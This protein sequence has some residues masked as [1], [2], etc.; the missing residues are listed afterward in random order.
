MSSKQI[1]M[2]FLFWHLFLVSSPRL[3]AQEK[4]DSIL[5]DSSI[6]VTETNPA[7]YINIEPFR[8]FV[9][10]FQS[11]IGYWH[12]SFGAGVA[13]TQKRKRTSGF[14]PNYQPNYSFSR[15]QLL[16]KYK[17]PN[18]LAFSKTGF[19]LHVKYRKVLSDHWWYSAKLAY[20]HRT[21]EIRNE[22]YEAFDVSA[23]KIKQ[24]GAELDLAI[25]FI[26]GMNRNISLSF[27]S[28]I[29]TGKAKGSVE[30]ID[31]SNCVVCEKEQQ[32]INSI[33]IGYN[34]G[35]RLGIL[36]SPQL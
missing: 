11:E 31:F 35:L 14:L 10:T 5:S 26:W 27:Y 19:D 7:F 32:E 29:L 16:Q 17:N 23:T 28:G 25:H 15:H 20:F 4:T 36:I 3:F 18:T 34:A 21:L 24:N 9:P 13:L 33:F 30:F 22:H 8:M 1:F 2:W 6:S 12:H